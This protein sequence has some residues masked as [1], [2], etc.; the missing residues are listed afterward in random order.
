LT[1]K[2]WNEIKRKERKELEKKDFGA[3]GPRFARSD[4]PDGDWMVV[5]S[6]WT[7][8][9]NSNS[10]GNGSQKG[11]DQSKTDAANNSSRTSKKGFVPI[12]VMTFL[13]MEWI[14]ASFYSVH[15]KGHASLFVTA[16]MK[17]KKS[18]SVA[19]SSSK[20]LFQGTMAAKLLMSA[21]VMQPMQRLV[22]KI[23]DRFQWRL[24]FSMFIVT[25]ATMITSLILS[26]LVTFLFGTG[27]V[28]I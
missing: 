26:T 1:E 13:I 11:S 20:F 12:Y 15:K 28:G 4:R 27:V 10:I 3:W 25:T 6:L 7:R 21:M 16:A 14:L 5:P 2:E 9:F 24:K 18:S 19:L 23:Q 17:M 8:G 22:M